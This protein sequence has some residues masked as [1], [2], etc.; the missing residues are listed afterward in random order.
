MNI[1]HECIDKLCQQLGLPGIITH[2][3]SIGQKCAQ[4]GKSFCDY[5][6]AILTTELKARQIRSQRLLAQMAGFPCIKTLDD[7]DFG[8]ASGV[9]KQQ[10]LELASL[11]FIERQE[12]IVFIGPSGVG[13]THL[14]VALGYLATQAGV[15]T[16]F[17]TAADLVFQLTAAKRHERYASVFKQYIAPRLLI[18]DEIGYLPLNQEQA[19]DFFQI[20]AKRYEKASLIMTS[21]LSFGQWDQA[22]GDSAITA[23]MLDRLL[24]HAHI[25][26]M[27]GESYRLR[28]KKSAGI[29][30]HSGQRKGEA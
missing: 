15:K 7:Y 18:I 6:E 3:D 29:L 13:K 4:E 10:L 23:A 12:N 11:S 2:Y 9:P 5:L 26:A 20:V 8:F 1:Q 28:E 14:A 24:H 17:V 21:N 30:V 22:F 16:R 19:N 25:L 27:R